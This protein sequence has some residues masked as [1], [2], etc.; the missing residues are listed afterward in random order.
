[1]NN[2]TLHTRR[3]FKQLGGL[4]R[5]LDSRQLLN[6]HQMLEVCATEYLRIGAE[7]Q[8]F[9]DNLAVD[10]GLDEPLSENTLASIKTKLANILGSSRELNLAVCVNLASGYYE[11]YKKS[12]PTY[13]QAGEDIRALQNTLDA[14]LQTRQ[15]FFVP[16]ERADYY[17]VGPWFPIDDSLY[18]GK[19]MES[20][21][22]VITAFPSSK[23]DIC[24]AGNCF[25]L[26]RPTATVF[27]LMRVMEA[28]LKATAK[29][30]GAAY[31]SDWG[32]CFR[33]IEKHGE[34]SDPFFKE[35]IAYL[36]SI[37]TVWRNPTMHIDRSFSEPEAER[38]LNAVSAFMAHLATRLTE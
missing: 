21:R 13:R 32:N 14:E 22:S 7:I 3:P 12:A 1:M 5:G 33:D 8:S 20:F 31:T 15:F 11:A 26:D 2:Q 9:C 16:P 25:A 17:C 6:L 28:G 37:K 36:R 23:N 10:V 18:L 27:H 38:I 24:E 19:K 29:A 35:A 30:L 4:P 34:Q